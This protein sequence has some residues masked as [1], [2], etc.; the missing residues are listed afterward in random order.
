MPQRITGGRHSI[1]DGSPVYDYEDYTSDPN[2]PRDVDMSNWGNPGVHTGPVNLSQDGFLG[3]DGFRP[4]RGQI[5]KWQPGEFQEWKQAKMSGGSTQYGRMAQQAH[6][7]R[8]IPGM[9]NL[10]RQ[11]QGQADQMLGHSPALLALMKGRR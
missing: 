2:D 4:M 1:I 3:R 11:G 6:S 9:L 7:M 8:K 10:L 5:P